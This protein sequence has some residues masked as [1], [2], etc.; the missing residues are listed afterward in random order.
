MDATDPKMTTP[1]R[2]IE[3]Q[4]RYRKQRATILGKNMAYV[5]TEGAGDPIVFLE[6]VVS[7][8]IGASQSEGVVRVSWFL[9]SGCS[10]SVLCSK[11]KVI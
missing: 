1:D 6:C 7:T 5:D 4:M 8:E 11:C 9:N 3:S 10:Y 2:P